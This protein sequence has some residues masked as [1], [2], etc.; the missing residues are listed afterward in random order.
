MS[1]VFLTH[2]RVKEKVSKKSLKT[3]RSVTKK[4]VREKRQSAVSSGWRV[5]PREMVG[6]RHTTTGKLLIALVLFHIS[7]GDS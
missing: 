1:G 5:G 6:W 2:G 7:G 4:K 3:T